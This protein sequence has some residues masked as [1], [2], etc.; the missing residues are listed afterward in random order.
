MSVGAAWLWASAFVLAFW[1]GVA[2]LVVT[3]R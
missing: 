2:E 3:F 1:L